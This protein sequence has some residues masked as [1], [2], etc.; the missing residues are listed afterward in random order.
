M[1]DSYDQAA[2]SRF[3]GNRQ[4]KFTAEEQQAIRSA[5]WPDENGSDAQE[6][7]QV[8]SDGSLLGSLVAC[9]VGLF[10][11]SLLSDHK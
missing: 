7:R 11:L 5:E 1:N 9:G 3:R 8:S 2:S 4:L 10:I 6:A